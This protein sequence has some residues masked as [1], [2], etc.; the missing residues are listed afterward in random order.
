MSNPH[1][2]PVKAHTPIQEYVYRIPGPPHVWVPSP[3][4]DNAEELSINGSASH[5]YDLTGFANVDFLKAVTYT[6]FNTPSNVLGWNYQQRWTAQAV[7]PFLCLGPT[8]VVRDGNFLQQHGITMILRIRVV[9]TPG[10]KSLGVTV[11]NPEI[12]IHTIDV[13]GMQDLIA[14]FPRGIEMINAHMSKLFN[15][16]RQP[17]ARSGSLA[18]S[19]PG[20]VLVCCETGNESSPCMVAAYLMAMYAMDLVKAIQIVQAQRFSASMGE[21]SRNILQIYHSIL[22]AQRNVIRSDIADISWASRGVGADYDFSQ[23][24]KRSLDEL[25][26]D[27]TDTDVAHMSELGRA[28]GRREGQAPFQDGGGF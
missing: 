1:E 11:A 8:S 19:P 16:K 23:A 2:T 10:S 6:N 22:E 24:N 13:G 18:N 4:V 20:T 14:A 15:D 3:V 9:L 12:E 21:E 25:Y 26:D 27:E 28:V 17:L 7:L 5:D